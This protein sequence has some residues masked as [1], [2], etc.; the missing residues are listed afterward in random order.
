MNF[1]VG[2]HTLF[3]INIY[4]SRDLNLLGPLK[5]ISCLGVQQ[6]TKHQQR[7]VPGVC[8]LQGVFALKDEKVN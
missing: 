5:K 1:R 2:K 6:L 4:F 7:R 3:R 8:V